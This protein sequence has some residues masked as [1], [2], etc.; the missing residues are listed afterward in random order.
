M[1]ETKFTKGE[2]VKN[3][4]LTVRTGAFGFISTE[5]SG[6]THSGFRERGYN[7][8]LIAAA[9]EMYAMLESLVD[10]QNKNYGHGM[11]T[12]IKLAA[13]AKDIQALLA[14]AQGETK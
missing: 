14:K 5:L 12:H 8:H 2:W 4:E 1:S 13:M 9:P 6:A 11:E 10:M 3:D 7:A